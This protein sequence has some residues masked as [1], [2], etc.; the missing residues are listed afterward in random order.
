MRQE[1]SLEENITN[2]ISYVYTKLFFKNARLIRRPFYLRGKRYFKFGKGLT[3]GYC[4]RFEIFSDK[5]NNNKN[6]KKLCI[7]ANCKM[8]DYV[9][10]SVCEKVEIGKNC[11]MASNIFISDNQHGVYKGNEQTS[12]EIVPDD[13]KIYSASI[14]IGDNVWI[15]EDVSILPNV[16]IGD[17]CIIGAKSLVNKSFPANCIIAGCPA[18]IIK[19]YIN[20]KWSLDEI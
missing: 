1:Y 2:L 16:R 11:L 18:K 9:H 10:I 4:C 6:D 20:H 14:Y 19:R 15:G 7:G 3:T 13:R 8:G 5:K 12:P 17:G